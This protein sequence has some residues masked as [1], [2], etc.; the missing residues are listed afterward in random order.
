MN[1]IYKYISKDTYKSLS[2]LFGGTLIA[3]II[4]LL[5]SPVISRL[6]APEYYGIL[7]LF[8]SISGLTG[9][10]AYAHYS[11]AI[12]LPKE[13]EDAKQIVWFS[14]FISTAV[15]IISA[16]ILLVLSIFTNIIKSSEIGWWYFLLPLSVF[17]NGITTV[18]VIW[19]N[20]TKHYKN[21]VFNRIVQSILTIA[22]QV[23]VGFFIHNE[24]GLMFGLL[25]GQFLSALL[26]MLEFYYSRKKDINIG[27][28]I[29]LG[30]K[31]IAFEYKKLLIYSTPTEFINNFINQTPIFLL[32][33]FAGASYVGNYSFAIRFL[34]LPEQFISGAIVNVFKQKAS[35]T[36]STTGGCRD[37]YLKTLKILS[38]LAIVPFVITVLFAPQIF[39]FVFGAKWTEAGIFAQFLSLIY[40]LRFIISPL[41]YTY[42]LARK[43]KEDFI[44][45]L[46]FLAM[47]TV[48][49]YI[50]NI[51]FTEKKLLI[52]GYSVSYSLIYLIYFYRSYKFSKNK[53]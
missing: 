39:S 47:T 18:L 22:L 38:A 52:L 13:N 16:L 36:Y 20:R 27:K 30:F 49:F 6:Y 10:V 50:T 3:S 9:V 14:L 33:K 29:L 17:F 4:P 28:P 45:H 32:Q 53:Q 5:A 26:L 12:M 34:G 2:T 43:F 46:L 19:A 37:I 25:F 48:S 8:M 42:I 21:L 41:T 31:K 23:S 35:E 7:G 11:Q 1:R 51:L 15:S 44:L 24:T 40:L